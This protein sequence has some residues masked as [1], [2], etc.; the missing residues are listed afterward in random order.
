MGTDP[1]IPYGWRGLVDPHNPLMWF[2]VL[3]VVTVGA[4]ALSGKARVGP[5]SVSAAI[6][7]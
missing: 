3:L 2:G 5:A 6:G 4:G 1:D 7:K